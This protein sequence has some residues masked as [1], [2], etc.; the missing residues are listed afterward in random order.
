MYYKDEI[1]TITVLNYD[2]TVTKADVV[3]ALENLGI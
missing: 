3:G 2:E 1:E